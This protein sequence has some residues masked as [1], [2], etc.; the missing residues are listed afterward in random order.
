MKFD[1]TKL[2]VLA[3]NVGLNTNV[4]I[5]EKA[6]CSPSTISRILCREEC[7]CG[8]LAKIASAI[9]CD[10]SELLPDNREVRG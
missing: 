3:L 2:E 7:R 10:V 6:G 1:R 8:S 9:G 5:A 4:A